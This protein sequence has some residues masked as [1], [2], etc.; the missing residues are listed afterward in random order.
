[1]GVQKINIIKEDL[2][3][4]KGS[5]FVIQVDDFKQK[6]PSIETQVFKHIQFRLCTQAVQLIMLKHEVELNHL[7]QVQ[8]TT[9]TSWS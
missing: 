1:M 5:S 7:A 3:A 8:L 9:P 6:H 4:L 2:T